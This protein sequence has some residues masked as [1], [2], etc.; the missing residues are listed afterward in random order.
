MKI[1]SI[2]VNSFSREEYTASQTPEI[3]NLNGKNL[4]IKGPN[5]SGK[6][7]TF[8]AT[9]H[10]VL[11]QLSPLDVY[12]GGGTDVSVGFDDGSLMYRGTPERR[13]RVIEEGKDGPVE[14]NFKKREA[15]KKLRRRIGPKDIVRNHFLPAETQLLPLERLEGEDRISIVQSAIDTSAREEMENRSEKLKELEKKEN[16]IEDS[17]EP[18]EKDKSR[19]NNQVGKKESQK[20]DWGTIVELSESGRLEKIQRRLHERSEIHEEFINLSERER[21]LKRKITSK[22][23]EVEALQRYKNSVEEI[24]AEAITEF[25]CPV[26]NEKVDTGTAKKRMGN[27]KCPF[28]NENRSAAQVKQHI[29]EQKSEMRGRPGK[30]TTEIA[31]HKTELERVQS[32]IEE[33]EEELPAISELNSLAVS[34]LEKADS[35]AQLEQKAQTELEKVSESLAEDRENLARIESE[36]EETKSE[37]DRIKTQREELKADLQKLEKERFGEDLINFQETLNAHFTN[38]G[39]E[40]GEESKVGFDEETG[41]ISLYSENSDPRKYERRTELS[42]S[43]I[44]LLN[45]SFVLS[46]NDYA[47]KSTKIDWDVVLLDEPF[48]NL[49]EET[50]KQAIGYLLDLPQQVVLTSSDEQVSNWFQKK[51]TLQL[52]RSPTQAQLDEFDQT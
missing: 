16:R 28:C 13:Y 18:L 10:V 23:K 21:G 38:I 9:A 50:S 24:I 44:Q 7:L 20:A 47:M 6:S 33:L 12:V 41:E 46:L 30:L 2:K 39:G 45:I 31:E 27:G 29:E 17:L 4:L 8:A 51:N 35:L 15:D 40:L 42:S 3:S 14:E 1:N 22:E 37:V 52:T 25:V 5:K 48:T 43:E 32:E 36:I 19:L 11:G 49:D 34:E 26:C